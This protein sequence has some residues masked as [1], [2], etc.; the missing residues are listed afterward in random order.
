LSG[1]RNAGA[2]YD[3]N[4]SPIGIQGDYRQA[5]QIPGQPVVAQGE[6]FQP[7]QHVYTTHHHPKHSHLDQ[8]RRYWVDDR[9]GQIIG[10]EGQEPVQR[11]GG[12]HRGIM[13]APG[14]GYEG[15]GQ[16]TLAIVGRTAVAVV[17]EAL[18]YELMSKFARGRGG[19]YNRLPVGG[20]G[21]GGIGLGGLGL[22]SG[23]YSGGY[24]PGYNNY[25]VGVPVSYPLGYNSYGVNPYNYANPYSY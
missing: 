21:L 17:G 6:Y 10:V 11:Y 1:S 13:G 16:S 24:Y 15:N 8:A 18:R 23:Y 20:M 19:Y 7:E 12:G 5:G 4:G 14:G 3:N 25:R 22:N 9:T 2:A